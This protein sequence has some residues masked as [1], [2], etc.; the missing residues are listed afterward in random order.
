MSKVAL[1]TQSR[2]GHAADV[3]IAGA[4]IVGLSLALELRE[5]GA[6]VIILDRSAAL[7]GASSA[8]AGMLAAEDPHNPPALLP[9][10]R[11]S[12]SLYPGFLSRIE[13][14]SGLTVPTQTTATLQHHSD[15]TIQRLAE[16][17]ID[18]RQLGPA[19][20]AA[21]R[22]A[23]AHILE[24]TTLVEA[25]V[26][27]SVVAMRTASGEMFE[28]RHLVQAT[29][30]WRMPHPDSASIPITPRKG[31]MLRVAGP[32][33][34]LLREVHRAEH[35]YVV[36]R[37]SGPQAGTALIGATVEDAGFDLSIQPERLQSLREAASALDPAT[38]FAARAPLVESW[39][40]VRPS[41]PD[42]L[43]LLGRLA[44][45]HEPAGKWI[46]S[47]HFR[48]GI[49]LAPGTARVMAD[50]LDGR[51]PAISMEPFAP[52]R[53]SRSDST[54]AASD[55]RPATR[56]KRKSHLR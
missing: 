29:G 6:S 4:G 23:S 19:L 36:P 39:A 54:A 37:T 45:G 27:P 46:A 33:E 12:L 28:A 1:A 18:P 43:P 13:A 7:S 11:Y 22:A 38:A 40:G 8:A 34:Y 21:A 17:S 50:L 2:P 47:G 31:Q 42:L 35:V 10:S 49:L 55:I 20:L 26:V 51:A 41:T 24:H 56:D 30:A 15:G 32:Q 14:L 52:E 3:L 44:P 5:R 25:N 48:N 53:F 16:I 9:L